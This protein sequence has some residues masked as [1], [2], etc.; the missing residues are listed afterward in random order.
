[1]Y[2]AKT[3]YVDT[4]NAESVDAQST[5]RVQKLCGDF[6]YYAIA[7]YQNMSVALNTISTAQSHTT[8]T[9]MGDIVCLLNW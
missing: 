3:Q 6:L 9:T 2:E 5:L 4:D 7:V 8:T 1:M